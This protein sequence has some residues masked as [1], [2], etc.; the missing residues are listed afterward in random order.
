MIK[1]M[2]KTLLFIIKVYILKMS[3]ILDGI[4]EGEKDSWLSF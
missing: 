2:R 4:R 3:F 1:K